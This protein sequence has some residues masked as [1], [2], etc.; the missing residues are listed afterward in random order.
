MHLMHMGFAGN[1]PPV[2]SVNENIVP[3]FNSFLNPGPSVHSP[4]ARGSV[5][6]LVRNKRGVLKAAAMKAATMKHLGAV[7]K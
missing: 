2:P 5:L 6:R 7:R 3:P 4:F 1:E